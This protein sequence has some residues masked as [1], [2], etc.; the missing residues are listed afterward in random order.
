[1][2]K[3]VLFSSDNSVAIEFRA[4]EGVSVNGKSPVYAVDGGKDDS[5][6]IVGN[7]ARN[8]AIRQLQAAEYHY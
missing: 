3:V 5:G 7:K 2:M 8:R 6:F 4:L 1:M